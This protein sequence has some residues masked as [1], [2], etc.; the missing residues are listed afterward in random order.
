M[1]QKRTKN[2]KNAQKWIEYRARQSGK[3]GG[4]DR[5]DPRCS[6]ASGFRDG[7]A[8]GGVWGEILSLFRLLTSPQPKST[9]AA[10]FSKK[11]NAGGL[12]EVNRPPL[13]YVGELE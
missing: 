1:S 9:R 3:V 10:L 13:L 4:N 12:V 8:E 11:P 6:G 2:S 7:V 5:A